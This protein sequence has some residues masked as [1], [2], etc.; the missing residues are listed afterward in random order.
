MSRV[1]ADTSVLAAALAPDDVHYDRARDWLKTTG[2]GFVTSVVAEVEL[3]RA[4]HRRQAGPRL[5]RVM[6][7]VLGAAEIVDLVPDVRRMAGVLTP[8]SLRSLD[9]MHVAT[10][11]VAEATEF[12]TFDV[13]QAVGAENAGLLLSPVSRI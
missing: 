8:A 12:A 9:A 2:R 6:Q 5:L 3:T 11:L 4:L 7:R 10:A 13:R 1:Y